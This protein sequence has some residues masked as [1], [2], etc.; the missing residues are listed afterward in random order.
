MYKRNNNPKPGV[1]AIIL[2]LAV[3]AAHAAA[4][5]V[6]VDAP[7]YVSN[8]SFD[9]AI[10]IDQVGDMDSGQFAISFNSSVLNVTD[11]KGDIKNGEIGGMEVPVENKYFIGEDTIG[12]LFNL[13]GI[14]GVSGSGSLATIVFEVVGN[15]GDTSFLNLSDELLV[16]TEADLIDADW[17]GGM[18]TIG[19]EALPPVLPLAEYAVTVYVK[20]IDDDRMDIHLLIDGADKGFERI[21]SGR[22]KNYGDYDLEEG[23]HRFTIRWFDPDTG[24]LYEKIEEHNITG[25]TTI[26]IRTD[27]HDKEVEGVSTHVYVKN[28]DNDRLDVY[29]Y[30]DESFKDFEDRISSGYTQKFGRSDGYKLTEGNHTFRIEWYDPDTGE[31][32]QTSRECLI[33]GDRASVTIYTEKHD[34]INTP[35]YVMNLDDDDLDIYLYIDDFFKDFEDRI[36]PG[37]TRKFGESA[38]YCEYIVSPFDTREFCESNGYK[39]TEGNHTF[40]IE[41]YDPDTGKEHQTSREC[42]ITRD[43]AITLYTKMQDGD[44]DDT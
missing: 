5:T 41:W 38:V 32:H 33:A 7:E 29:L 12:L 36:L 23:V 28:L 39:L 26:M 11:I 19:D 9:A 14:S 15:D 44:A 13:P 27:E 16:N 20:N 35:V 24:E 6:S 2:L 10:R 42:L 4:V 40:R 18:V 17:I 30:I 8:S 34:K 22:A 21:S 1:A 25:A 43:V 37:Y 3:C 31:E